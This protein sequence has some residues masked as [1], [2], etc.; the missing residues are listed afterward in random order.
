MRRHE[1]D[2]LSFVFGLLFAG[3]GL[4]LLG[5]GGVAAGLA[6]PWAGPVVAIGLGIVMVIA[7]RPRPEKLA[8][9]AAHESEADRVAALDE[10]ADKADA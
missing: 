1:F 8:S 9:E 10:S 4:V 6:V 2:P 7:A 5:G 3:T